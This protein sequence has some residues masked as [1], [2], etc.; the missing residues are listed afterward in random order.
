M[1]RIPLWLKDENR[2]AVRRLLSPTEHH[3][4]LALVRRVRRSVRAELVRAVLFGSR[5]RGD[6]RPD[7]DLDV[8]LI[9]R[10]LPPDREPYASQAEDLAAVVARRTGVPVECWSVSLP[11]LL[12]GERT[13][14]LVDALADG[15]SLWPPHAEPL[16]LTFTRLDAI[17]CASALLQRLDEGREEV[18]ARLRDGD[19]GSAEVR[20]RDDLV[21]ICTAI[22]LLHGR[23]RPRRAESVRLLLAE[24]CDCIPLRADE[25][26]VLEWA[27]D[28]YGAAGSHE[29]GPVQ[30]PPGDLRAVGSVID[31]LRAVVVEICGEADGC[32]RWRVQIAAGRERPG[33]RTCGPFT[34]ARSWSVPP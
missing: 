31:R 15:I 19:A 1:H 7:S 2:R 8:L 34:R 27:A 3:A 21:R 28:S 33:H 30:S 29:G 10:W 23:T 17:R 12:E 25:R 6:A 13:P 20:A 11:D 22:H 16:A 24:Q 5:A 26:E 18:G 14:M 32:S 4:A 9:F